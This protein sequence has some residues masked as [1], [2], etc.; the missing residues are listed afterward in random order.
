[1][2]LEALFRT[3]E[4]RRVSGPSV[5]CYCC[6]GDQ[7]V[8]RQRWCKDELE[9]F[10]DRCEVWTGRCITVA[11]LE[12]WVRQKQRYKFP[13]YGFHETADGTMDRCAVIASRH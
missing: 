6:D 13:L 12:V 5:H 1:M 7:A 10:C 4:G 2:Q 3:L 9:L 11:D 8:L